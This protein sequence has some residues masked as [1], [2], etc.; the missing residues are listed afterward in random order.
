[1]LTKNTTGFIYPIYLYSNFGGV[2]EGV[3]KMG[4]GENVDLKLARLDKTN[5]K[6]T[7]CFSI[8]TDL[9]VDLEMPSIR[10]GCDMLQGK[11]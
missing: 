8:N 9:Q 10:N 3:K 6:G 5:V 4:L 11:S 7:Q 2:R 1:L